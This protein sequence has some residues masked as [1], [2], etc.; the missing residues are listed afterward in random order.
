MIER[1]RSLDTNFHLPL[2]F[3]LW[4]FESDAESDSDSL[5]SE[6]RMFRNSDSVLQEEN[7]EDEEDGSLENKTSEGRVNV[8]EKVQQRRKRGGF[9]CDRTI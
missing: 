1:S 7:E 2:N 4:R 5:S 6:I 3:N 9:E 8:E